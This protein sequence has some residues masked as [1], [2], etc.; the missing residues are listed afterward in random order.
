MNHRLNTLNNFER[1][2][3]VFVLNTETDVSDLPSNTSFAIA[4][5][6]NQNEVF[7]VSG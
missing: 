4:V 7:P 1:K 3:K 2:I 6:S 5:Q